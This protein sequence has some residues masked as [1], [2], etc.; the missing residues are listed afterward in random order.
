MF[1]HKLP[2]QEQG[3][4]LAEVLIAILV[5]TLFLTFALQGMVLAALF[6]A[7]ARQFSEATTWIQADL[8]IVKNKVAELPLPSTTLTAPAIVGA[9]ILTVDSVNGFAAGDTLKVGS[10]SSTYTIASGGINPG[11]KTITLTSG[12]A[13]A[14]S[15]GDSVLARCN[16]SPLT[17]TLTTGFGD[18]LN[19][20]MPALTTNNPSTGTAATPTILGKTYVITRI[21]NIK[22][23]DVN[24]LELTYSVAPQDAHT[25][26]TAAASSTSTS[27]AVASATGFKAGDTLTVG[28]DIDNQIQSI[29]GNTIT[30]TSQLETAQA[31]GAVVDASIATINTEVI[32]D[33]ALQCPTN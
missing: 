15:S 14:Q 8:E 22:S 28:T 21:P 3:F 1:K 17:P 31:S 5:A 4:T 20:N 7:R 12:L 23:S 30:L 9:T 25:T 18:Y 2:Q 13:T 10:N 19:D 11:A 16:S 33:A 27:I 32:P 26:L 29:S 24:V 6:K